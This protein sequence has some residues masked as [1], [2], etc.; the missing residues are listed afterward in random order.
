MQCSVYNY[1]KSGHRTEE[2]NSLTEDFILKCEAEVNHLKHFSTDF[3]FE[4]VPHDNFIFINS[5]DI[6][7]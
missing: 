6:L 3:R 7:V 1:M 2:S 5:K 4:K